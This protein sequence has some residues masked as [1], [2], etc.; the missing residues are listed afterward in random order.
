M[1]PVEKGQFSPAVSDVK[2][3]QWLLQLPVHPSGE[4]G[5]GKLRESEREVFNINCSTI[6]YMTY[7][8]HKTDAIYSNLTSA[9]SHYFCKQT[10]TIYAEIKKKPSL[11]S[12]FKRS[13]LFWSTWQP[14]CHP[15]YTCLWEGQD[16]V[17]RE[18]VLG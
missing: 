12:F 9:V 17:T 14:S 15:S 10:E 8:L 7:F 1:F 2:W 13:L 11:L 16:K 5:G 6:K 4:G 18:D 3:I